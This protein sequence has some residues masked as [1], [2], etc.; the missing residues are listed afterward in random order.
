[1]QRLNTQKWCFLYVLLFLKAQSQQHSR[2]RVKLLY[3]WLNN[4]SEADKIITN[5]A[6]FD[7]A[8]TVR[9]CGDGDNRAACNTAGKW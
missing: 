3:C 1:M 4:K 5:E 8:V 7:R 2:V 9:H 6:T